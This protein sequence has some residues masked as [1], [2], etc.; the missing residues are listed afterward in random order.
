MST[1]GVLKKSL[2]AVALCGALTA[3]GAA[4][5]PATATA[6]PAVAP[7]AAGDSPV[8]AGANANLNLNV[9]VLGIANKIESSIKTSANR[10]AFVKNLMESAYYAGGEKYNV[11]VHN[12]NQDY[13][14]N[15][16]GVQTYGSATY[17]G[18]TFGIWVFKDGEFTNKGD[19]G[20]INWAMKG[21]FQRDGADGKHVTFTARF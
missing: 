2:A 18:V 15:L 11:V 17:D 14:E 7:S 5:F 8:S 6:A 16:N 19:G 20:W 4:A 13:E 9:D 3:A 10:D 1:P 21:S 12:L